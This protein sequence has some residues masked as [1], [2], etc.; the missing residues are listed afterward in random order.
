MFS[1][2]FTIELFYLVIF[3]FFFVGVTVRVPQTTTYVVNNGLTL[4]S[5]GPQLTVHHRPPQ[6]HTVSVD[7]WFC[8]ILNCKGI[9]YYCSWHFS[10]KWLYP[11][12]LLGLSAFSEVYF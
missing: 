12:E 3:F 5:T 7:A 10:L 1:T 6:V 2:K 8:K 4:G 9:K 11:R